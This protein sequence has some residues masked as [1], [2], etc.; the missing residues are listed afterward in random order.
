MVRLNFDG[1]LPF[2]QDEVYAAYERKA[3]DAFD[4]LRDETGAGNDFLGWKTLPSDTPESLIH[5]CEAVRDAWKAKGVNLV[6][7]I[8]IGG[9]YLGANAP[10]KR[11]AMLSSARK[12]SRRSSSPATT[13]PRSILPN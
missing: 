8:G 4:V 12:G 11:S 13:S 7:V 10:S 6:V 2:I 9:S 1:C 3:F 5:D